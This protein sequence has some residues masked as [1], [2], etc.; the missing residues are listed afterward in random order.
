MVAFAESKTGTDGAA[1]RAAMSRPGCSY[2]LQAM[3]G[4]LDVHR[5]T[6][7]RIETQR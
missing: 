3:R 5:I 6:F 7:F 1:M 2:E 4:D